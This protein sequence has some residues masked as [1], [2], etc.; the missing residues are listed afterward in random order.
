MVKAHTQ[1][2]EAFHTYW[3]G[4]YSGDL[5]VV[6]YEDLVQDIVLQL[7]RIAEFVSV[8]VTDTV[9]TCTSESS[10]GKHQRLH[11]KHED[12]QN[13]FTPEMLQE[14]NKVLVHLRKITD[15][16]FPDVYYKLLKQTDK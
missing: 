6:H 14:I 4:E 1:S 8:P 13:K 9:M 15:E 3:L 11:T 12:R 5:I 10:G 7:R 16:E 2:W